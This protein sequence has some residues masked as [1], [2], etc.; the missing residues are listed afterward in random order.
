MRVEDSLKGVQALL[1]PEFLDD[2]RR[3]VTH[4]RFMDFTIGENV[5]QKIQTDFVSMRQANPNKVS[6]DHLHLLLTLARLVSLSEGQAE[7]TV[8]TWDRIVQMEIERESR[9]QSS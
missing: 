8:E 1:T 3:Y 5:Q 9:M 7:L 2:V 6:P 4:V